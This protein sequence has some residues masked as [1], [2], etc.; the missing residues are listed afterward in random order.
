MKIPGATAGGGG[1][2]CLR[3]WGLIRDPL[4]G[5][6]GRLPGWVWVLVGIFD[7][8]RGVSGTPRA[9]TGGR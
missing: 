2:F 7:G 6:L 8:L 3:V 1:I 9:K 5:R 4:G